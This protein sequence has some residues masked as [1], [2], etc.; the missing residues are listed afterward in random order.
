MLPGLMLDKQKEVQLVKF[1]FFFTLSP[2]HRFIVL[3]LDNS[4]YQ[5]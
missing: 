4:F 5:S 3:H 1:F 2:C